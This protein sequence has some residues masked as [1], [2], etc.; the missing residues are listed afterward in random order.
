MLLKP[1]DEAAY[2]VAAPTVNDKSAGAVPETGSEPEPAQARASD[3]AA[4]RWGRRLLAGAFAVLVILVGLAALIAGRLASGPVSLTWAIPLLEP[5]F[6]GRTGP[7]DVAATTATLDWRDWRQGPSLGLGGVTAE[8]PKFNLAIGALT[9][10]VSSDD[11]LAGRLI[12]A[13]SDGAR[14]PPDDAAADGARARVPRTTAVPWTGSP[15]SFVR[16]ST[17][18]SPNYRR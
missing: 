18:R 12:L 5:F 17:V 1:T 4:S 16:R 15:L 6:E 2:P 14:R 7:I 10:A 3:A 8:G 9:L 13:P 11:L